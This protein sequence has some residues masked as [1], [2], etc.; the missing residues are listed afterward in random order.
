MK[1]GSG[2]LLGAELCTIIEIDPGIVLKKREPRGTWF[3][4]IKEAPV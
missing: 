3:C 2:H 4:F 1:T